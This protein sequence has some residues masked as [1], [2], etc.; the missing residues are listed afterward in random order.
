MR[1]VEIV[2]ILA[3]LRYDLADQH[4]GCGPINVVDVTVVGHKER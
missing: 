3:S 1:L 4:C 2:Y